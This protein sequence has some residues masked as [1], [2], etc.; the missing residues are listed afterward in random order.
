MTILETLSSFLKHLRGGASLDPVRDWLM[1]LTLSII[2]L[3]GIIVWNVWAFSTVAA[4]GTIGERAPGALPLFDRSALDTIHT[5]FENR[6]VEEAKY[7][8]GVY[9]FVDPSQQ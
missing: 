4:G 1:V 3:A 2:T 7:V 6:A 5:I 9:R 8:T